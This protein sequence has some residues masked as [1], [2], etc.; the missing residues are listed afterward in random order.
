MGGMISSAFLT[1]YIVPVVYTV[2]SDLTEKL[3]GKKQGLAR[4]EYAVAEE[5]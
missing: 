3:F 1:L 5:S 4:P 2:L